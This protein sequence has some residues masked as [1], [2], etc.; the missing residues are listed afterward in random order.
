MH[1]DDLDT[2]EYK[3][4]RI[5]SLKLYRGKS[6]KALCTLFSNLDLAEAE[7]KYEEINKALGYKVDPVDGDLIVDPQDN[8]VC[9]LI[10]YRKNS[11]ACRN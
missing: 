1:P 10:W 3:A 9:A 11:R 6:T 4:P 8:Q 7:E 5:Y 2:V